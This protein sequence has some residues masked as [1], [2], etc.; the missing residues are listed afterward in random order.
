ML[1]E[2][3]GAIGL[4]FQDH[5]EMQGYT[6]PEWSHMTG[7]EADRFTVTFYELVQRKLAERGLAP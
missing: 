1:L 7:A 6:L 3:T 4:H 5:E 2:R